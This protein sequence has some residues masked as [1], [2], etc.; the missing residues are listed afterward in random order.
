MQ[1]DA[2]ARRPRASGATTCADLSGGDVTDLDDLDDETLARR[3]GRTRKGRPA[4]RYTMCAHVGDDGHTHLAVLEGRSLVEHYVSSLTD[5]DTSIDGNIYLGKVQN[6]LPGME[7]AF[8]DIGTPKNGVLYRGDVRS[9]VT[10]S[11]R[12]S[13]ASSGCSRTARR[14]WC[15]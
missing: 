15:R 6:V 1:R 13:P 14:S 10:R 11:R 3:R 5:A 8:I 7:A 2:A 9:T 12:A 4:G